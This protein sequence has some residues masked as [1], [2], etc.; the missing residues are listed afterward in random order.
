MFTFTYDPFHFWQCE[1]GFLLSNENTKKLYSY[2]SIDEAINSLYV[3]GF[4]DAA[5][6]LNKAKPQ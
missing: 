4:K 6:A 1:G 5:R 2:K 3:A